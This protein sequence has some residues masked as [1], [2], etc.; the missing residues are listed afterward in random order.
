M[1]SFEGE[2]FLGTQ[3]IMAKLQG[4]GKVSHSM[5]SFDAQPSLNNGIVCMVSGDLLIGEDTNPLKFAQVFYL[6]QGGAAGYYCHND[7][8]RLNYG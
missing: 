2:Q 1:L 4:L 6:V 8:F 5:K 7:V 3:Q